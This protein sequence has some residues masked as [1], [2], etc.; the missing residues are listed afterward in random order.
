MKRLAYLF[1]FLPLLSAQDF[2]TGQAARLVVG[3]PNYTEQDP[4]STQKTLGSAAGVAYANNTLFVVDSNRLGATPN[5]NR[6]LIYKNVSSFIPGIADEPPQG[7]RCPAC[8][9]VPDV[10]LGQKDFVT[11]EAVRPPAQDNVRNPV[12]VA[13]DGTMIAVAD[14]DNNRILIWRSIPST[15][16][17]PADLVLGQKSFTSSTPTLSAS[18]LR[19]P[20]GV[21]FDRL[22]GLWVA[23]TGNNRVLYYGTPTQNGQDAKLVLGQPD[24]NTNPLGISATLP[25]ATGQNMLSPTSVTTDGLRLFVSDLGFSRVQIWNSIP[26]SNGQRADVVVGQNDFILGSSNDVAK[27][28]DSNGTDSTGALNLSESVCKDAELSSVCFVGW[29]P[30]VYC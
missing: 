11:A 28:C 14:T 16:M 25:P 19:G 17:A 21:W 3:Q 30:V 5:N 29:A 27:L 18:G 1:S 10:V 23:D 8:V 6:I 26:T 4:I 2:S 22:G 15:N 7:T 9:G 24:F 20:Q 12:A 13:S